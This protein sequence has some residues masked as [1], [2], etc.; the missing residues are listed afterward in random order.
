M[1]IHAEI[2]QNI[3][4]LRKEKNMTQECLALEAEMSVSYLRS[5]EHGEA[6][7]SMETL[8]RI[9]NA[10]NEPFGRVVATRERHEEL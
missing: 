3:L 10:L 9:A 4:Q 5:I 7:P 8:S 6:N 1:S 2:G